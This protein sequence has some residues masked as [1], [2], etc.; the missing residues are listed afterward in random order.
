M[1]EAAWLSN[2]TRRN[3][4][5]CV[6]AIEACSAAEVVVTVSV[7]SG[8]YRH[9]DYLAGSLMSLAA[10]LLYFF[11]PEPVFDDIAVI[12]VVASFGVGALLS[13][14]IPG[15]R[16]LLVSRRVM[17][18]NVGKTAR[19]CFVDQRIAETMGRTGILVYVSL[20]ERRV[21]VVADSAVPT[22][23]LG[24]RWSE[25][26]RNLETAAKRG[27]EPFLQALASLGA[28]LGEALPRRPDDI[29]ELSDDM[30]QR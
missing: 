2:E 23:Q 25:A 15:L 28:M 22:T 1:R 30:V 7:S 8:H 19:A 12:V 20:F 13:A 5:D 17:A 16:R 9:A 11:Y 10:L 14:A 18:D 27:V 24:Q 29:N 3:V 26:V 21:E 6:A 4:R